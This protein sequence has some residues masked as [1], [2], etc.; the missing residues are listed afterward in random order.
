MKKSVV[1]FCIWSC[2]LIAAWGG[3]SPSLAQETSVTAALKK[4]RGE[5]GCSSDSPVSFFGPVAGIAL[6]RLD[7]SGNI[8]GE[9]TIASADPF[10][11]LHVVLSGRLSAQANGALRGT[12]SLQVTDPPGVPDQTLSL[13]CIGMDTQ[14]DRYREMRCL[15]ITN[16]PDGTDLVGVL[17]CKSR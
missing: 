15:D 9:E 11:E 10:A 17:L 5:W 12:V 13:L 14:G 4:Y 16:E 3:A 1:S 6:L 2:A 7:R 8:T